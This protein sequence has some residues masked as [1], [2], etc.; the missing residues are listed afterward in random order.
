MNDLGS[1]L[2]DQAIAARLVPHLDEL[3]DDHRVMLNRNLDL[4]S[5]LLGRAAAEL[6]WRR[7][8]GGPS[9]WVELPSG[10]AVGVH[11]RWRCATGSRSSP[12]TRCRRRAT[13]TAS[14]ACPT[15]AEPPVLEETMRR[16]AQAWEAYAPSDEPPPV[17]PVA[18]PSSSDQRFRP[19]GAPTLSERPGALVA[20]PAEGCQSG[21]MGRPRKP[22]WPPGHHGFESHTFRHQVPDGQPPSGVCRVIPAVTDVLTRLSARGVG[23]AC[24]ACVRL[25]RRRAGAC[26]APRVV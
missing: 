19:T 15:R 24:P 12:A 6:A 11:A 8:K 13:T 10:T 7:P 26:R 3:R 9:L 14:C 2:F 23:F 18:A 1:P 5:G 22:L 21:R 20:S 17:T 4:V 25:G 16:L